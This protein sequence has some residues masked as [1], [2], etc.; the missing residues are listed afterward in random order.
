MIK[1]VRRSKKKSFSKL[2]PSSAERARARSPYSLNSSLPATFIWLSSLLLKLLESKQKHSIELT[3]DFQALQQV[4]AKDRAQLWFVV[5]RFHGQLLQPR[6]DS[7]PSEYLQSLGPLLPELAHLDDASNEVFSPM[8]AAQLVNGLLDVAMLQVHATVVAIA[9]VFIAQLP[10]K[11]SVSEAVSLVKRILS[12]VI[13]KWEFPD[14]T[15]FLRLLD[16]LHQRDHSGTDVADFLGRILRPTK[17][18][19]KSRSKNLPA[20]PGP[21]VQQIHRFVRTCPFPHGTH[22]LGSDLACA[23]EST[24]SHN[25]II[26]LWREL[27]TG[28]MGVL[29]FDQGFPSIIILF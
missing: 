13:V 16:S 10:H 14:A 26:S 24:G 18:S 7:H 8:D 17:G 4:L 19:G 22:T 6:S 9:T 25:E 15:G 27:E 20:V 5:L 1:G 2:P 11:T 21:T 3:A 28:K 29:R 23:Y 12:A